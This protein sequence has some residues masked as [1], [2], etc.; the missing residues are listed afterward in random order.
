MGKTTEV[1]DIKAAL[2]KTT[3]V[4]KAYLIR[5]SIHDDQDDPSENLADMIQRVNSKIEK[6]IEITP[7]DS[8][9][10]PK[11]IEDPLCKGHG[12]D[13]ESGRSSDTEPD[14]EEPSSP[15]VE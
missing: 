1:K 5:T 13:S 4:D 14:P 7:K 9:Q 11:R 2:K 8:D 3:S 12:S 10:L 6:L 15:N